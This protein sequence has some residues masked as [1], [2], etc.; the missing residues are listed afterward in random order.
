MKF[1]QLGNGGGLDPLSTNSSFLIEVS[2]NEYL[3][4]DCGFNIMQRLIQ[5]EKTTTDF[6]IKQI[7]HV[8]IS[9]IHDDHVGNLETLMF[10]NYFKNNVTMTYYAANME[11]IQYLKLKITNR[12]LY[13][14]GRTNPKVSITSSIVELIDRGA[15][16]IN[17]I[18]LFPLKETFHGE[19]Q[20]NGLVISDLDNERSIVITGDTKA[21]ITLEQEIAS[22]TNDYLEDVII[23]HDYSNWDCPSKNVHTCKSD[24]EAEY[25]EAF[26]DKVIKYHNNGKY[27]K[28]WQTW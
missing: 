6:H 22:L 27:K 14:G 7:K 24:F 18:Y 12:K 25:S 5:L 4:F 1:I 19:T 9:H 16:I 3:L 11:V 15:N 2:K 10:W 8:F 28:E 21:S 17:N 13:S 20:S 26:R 23:Y